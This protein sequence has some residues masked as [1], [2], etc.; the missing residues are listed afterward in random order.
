MDSDNLSNKPSPPQKLTVGLIQLAFKTADV[1]ANL[2]EAGRLIDE[3][4]QK[5]AQLVAL[6]ELW[7]FGY[8]VSDRTPFEETI[9]DG[10][11]AKFMIN[12]AK[13]HQIYVCGGFLEKNPNGGLPYNGVLLV[14]PEGTILLNHHKVELYTPGGE[15]KAFTSGDKFDIVD[16]PLGR[17]AVLDSYDG[18]FPESWR[19]VAAIKGADL[20]IHPSAY[21]SPCEDWWTKLYEASA[22]ANAV[23]AVNVNLAGQTGDSNLF[24]GSCIIDPMGNT[25][26][27]AS[28]VKAGESAKSEVLVKEL[29]FAEGLKMGKEYNG[30]LVGDRRVDVFRKYGL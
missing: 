26:A 13:E 30:A 3:A 27:H 29:D 12:K 24:G 9:P 7:S 17:L 28:Y 6:S 4:A 20:V 22:L 21:E 18:D 10:K 25:I 23:W 16:T 1:D 8:K 2:K 11:T 14:G 15:D 5:G 19:I